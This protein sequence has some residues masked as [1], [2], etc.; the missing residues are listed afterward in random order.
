MISQ[1]HQTKCA[2]HFIYTFYINADLNIL[3][4]HHLFQTLLKWQK[5]DHQVR[6]CIV[7]PSPTSPHPHIDYVHPP[8]KCL[9]KIHVSISF[10]K[11]ILFGYEI[12]NRN[13]IVWIPITHEIALDIKELSLEESKSYVLC[14]VLSQKFHWRHLIISFDLFHDLSWTLYIKNSQTLSDNE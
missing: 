5:E 9:I 3:Q 1:Q 7:K 10:F 13:F 12:H 6:L 14:A 4:Y 2:T 8:T 11:H